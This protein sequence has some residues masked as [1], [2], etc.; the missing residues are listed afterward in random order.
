V[1]DVNPD[2]PCEV[3]PVLRKALAK[4]PADRYGSGAEFVAALRGSLDDAAGPTRVIG[5]PVP[6]APARQTR[7]VPRRRRSFLVPVIALAALALVGGGIAA[8]T[9]RGGGSPHAS[10]VVVRTVTQPGTTVVTTA[11]ATTAAATTAPATTAAA[12]TAPATTAQSPGGDPYALNN[13]AYELMK[14]GDYAS[15]LPLL[16]SAVSQLSGRTDLGTAYANYNLGVTLMNLGHCSD[17]LPYLET[18]RSIQ[19]QRREVKDAIKQ[20]RHCE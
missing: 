14:Q 12:T 2:V 6:P 5:P 10:S 11:P 17:A 3:D 20:A 13:Q 4:S 19:P 18:S 9:L 8:M 15:A 7:P 1:C 16:Q